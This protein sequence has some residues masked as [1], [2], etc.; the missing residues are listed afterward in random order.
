[1]TTQ[2]SNKKMQSA[3][4]RPMRPFDQLQQQLDRVFADFSN[5]FRWP[6]IFTGETADVLPVMEVISGEGTV[7]VTAELPGVDEKEIDISL[8]DKTLT[9]SGE[10]KS[11][12][13]TKEDDFCRSERAYG[14]FS[15]S[16]TLPF[17]IDP[18]GVEARFDKGVLTLTIQQPPEPQKKTARIEIMH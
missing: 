11:E 8:V 17:E 15:R 2:P 9:I 12:N 3:E 5:G 16:V 13:Q 4:V 6:D 7:T 14:S 18:D 1:M 10:K